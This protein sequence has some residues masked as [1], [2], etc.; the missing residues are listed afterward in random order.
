MKCVSE[1]LTPG[2]G[3][4]AS[5]L[6][7]CVAGAVAAAAL[8]QAVPAAA[9]GIGYRIT[10]GVNHIR[11]DD[12]L[13]LK[14]GYLYGG[15]FGITFG[16]AVSLQP[17]YFR[18]NDL[19]ADA[20][21]IEGTS[22]FAG[23]TRGDVDVSILGANM[24]VNLGSG[25][26]IPFLRGGGGVL[27][28]EPD[29]RER[30]D[31]IALV[32]GGGLRFGLDRA[33]AE[34]FVEDWGFRLDRSRLYG[35]GSTADPD[36]E[37]RHNL[38]VGAGLSITLGA[39]GGDVPAAAGGG[40]IPIEPFVGRLEWDDAL[41]LDRQNL[42]GVRAGIDLNSYVGVRGFYWRGVNDDFDATED[43]SSYGGEA[44]FNLNRGT[45]L[46][47]YLVAGAG[48]IDF[49]SSF[50][51]RA[52]GA[53]A[54]ITALILGGGVG[55]ALGEHLRVNVAARNHLLS[56]DTDLQDLARTDDLVSNWMFS[57]GITLRL[58]GSAPAT[59]AVRPAPAPQ[60]PEVAALRRETERLRAETD[61]L[62]AERERESADVPATPL[63]AAD[64]ARLEERL[65]ERLELA[66]ARRDSDATRQN[67]IVIVTP[68]AQPVAG[69]TQPVV[70]GGDVA[71]IERRLGE[72][73]ARMADR[74]ATSERRM[75]EDME[76]REQ[77]LERR[78]QALLRRE[79]AP[80]A[81]RVIVVD[82]DS[83]RVV[84]VA[85]QPG[86]WTVQEYR[87]Y[88]GINLSDPTQLVFGGRADVGPVTPGSPFRVVPEVAFGAGESRRTVLAAANLLYSFGRLGSGPNVKPYAMLGAGI[89]SES[90]LTLNFAY[91]ATFDL[92]MFGAERNLFIEHQGLNLFDRNRLL[93]G[94]R[95]MR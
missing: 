27:R 75:R 41:D 78:E 54:D 4:R 14:D 23:A 39:A 94:L 52:G 84:T 64:L 77:A 19:D 10:P 2:G 37:Y 72:F 7:A 93:F 38:V 88:T 63:R 76:R 71:A 31:Q 6:R 66:L 43:I 49:D 42:A 50:V 87:V 5:M 25:A 73:E 86:Q 33:T 56:V 92:D 17:F 89:F 13:G 15:R 74:I 83:A 53:R 48:R 47:P 60:D 9:Q 65:M 61:R 26:V 22:P 16:P 67:P 57:T 21:R 28:I 51:N 81:E 32:A 80:A 8:G 95:L 18:S 40:A 62:R 34:V 46:V 58:G 29:G 55:F 24:E 11:W 70:P 35:A 30:T 85:Q 12:A 90:V 79:Q 59:V 45:G 69:A 20:T 44:Q 68:G 3:G 82:R 36:D 1:G 91:G